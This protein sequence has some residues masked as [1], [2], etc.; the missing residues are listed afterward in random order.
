MKRFSPRELRRLMDRLGVSAQPLTDVE[1]AVFKLKDGK[2]LV[3]RNPTI[4]MLDFQGQKIFQVIG[5]SLEERTVEVKGKAK[6]KIPEEDVALVAEQ[7]GVSLEEARA[8]LE[9]TGG[10]LAQAILLLASRRK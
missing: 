5:E 9:E 10:D 4:T 7:A 1:E 3:I 8:A 2:E 6:P